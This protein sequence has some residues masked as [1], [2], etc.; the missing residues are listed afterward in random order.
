MMYGKQTIITPKHFIM[1]HFRH[2][3]SRS[4]LTISKIHFFIST[5]TY[6]LIEGK[7]ACILAFLV[8]QVDGHHYHTFQNLQDLFFI[9]TWTYLLIEGKSACIL[10]FLVI[11]VDGS[12]QAKL[13]DK[14]L[15]G[16]LTH[17]ENVTFFILNT[18]AEK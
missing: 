18:L 9:S 6:L 13:G 15:D 1:P 11:Q 10:A 14:H 8:I 17:K 2:P 3:L 4:W 5:W 12:L 7:S 16:I